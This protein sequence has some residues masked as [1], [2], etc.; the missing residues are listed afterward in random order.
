MRGRLQA[1]ASFIVS[2]VSALVTLL[3]VTVLYAMPWWWIHRMPW[4]WIG[5]GGLHGF[6]PC[7]NYA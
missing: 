4:W 3:V 2:K 7:L 5:D 6:P 1:S